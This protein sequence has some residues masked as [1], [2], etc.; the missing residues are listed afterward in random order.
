MSTPNFANK[1]AS[2]VFAFEVEDEFDYEDAV[3]NVACALEYSK[4]DIVFEEE[5][6]SDG[7]RSYPGRVFG[8]VQG[9]GKYYEKLDLQVDVSLDVVVRSGYY[10]GGNFDYNFKIDLNGDVVD[11]VED[12]DLQYEANGLK[13]ARQYE[14]YVKAYVEKELSRLQEVVEKVYE[15]FTT[16]LKCLGV[17]SNGEAFYERA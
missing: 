5:N 17:A 16:P 12:I 1:N 4:E 13:Q 2:R 9:K 3:S 7:D 10:S 11:D 15:Q 8:E 6:K 14:K